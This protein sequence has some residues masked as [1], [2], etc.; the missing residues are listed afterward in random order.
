MCF[1]TFYP[2]HSVWSNHSGPIVYV[3]WI[4]TWTIHIWVLFNFCPTFLQATLSYIWNDCQRRHRSPRTPR[5]GGGRGGMYSGVVANLELWERSEVFFLSFPLH[6]FSPPLPSPSFSFFPLPSS[7]L[8]YLVAI[9]SMIF[10][11][12]N[13]P[14]TLHCF[15]SLLGGTQLY[16][17]SP[18]PDR[19]IIWGTAFSHKIFGG[20]AFPRVPPRLHH[21]SCITG[22]KAPC[23]SEGLMCTC[24]GSVTQRMDQVKGPQRMNL[25]ESDN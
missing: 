8:S 6:S 16:H 19:P 4:Y 2:R 22:W 17:L 1:M 13:L 12:I 3:N 24:K 20:T 11:R 14:Q 9:I 23:G 5:Q 15:A 7:S 10:L 21:C 18:C 25:L